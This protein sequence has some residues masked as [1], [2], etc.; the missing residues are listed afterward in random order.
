MAAVGV[1]PSLDGLEHRSAGILSRA[2]LVPVQEFALQGGNEALAESVVVGVSHRSHRRAYASLP[3][4]LAE[5]QRGVLAALIR[6]MDH[7]LRASLADGHFE[8]VENQLG[9]QVRG[10]RPADHAPAPGIHNHGQVQEA[11]PG[12]DVGDVR[13]PKPVWTSHGEIE[14][15]QVRRRLSPR[16]AYGRAR[17]LALAHA[18]QARCS[19]QAR[20]PLTAH[21]HALIDQFGVDARRAIGASRTQM[22]PT[23]PLG[24]RDVLARTRRRRSLEPRV[25]PAGGDFQQAA[26]HGYRIVGRVCFHE[27]EVSLGVEPVSRANQAAAFPEGH[28]DSVLGFRVPGAAAGFHGADAQSP[29]APLWPSRHVADLPPDRPA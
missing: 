29:R 6:V 4:A 21:S 17:T 2:E 19:H 15:H 18:T 7:T 1:I 5:G 9:P 28:R 26:H 22:D 25:V 23:D 12:S 24:K 10:H 14:L 3:A 16:L 27:L 20:H 13:Y 11:R 8:R